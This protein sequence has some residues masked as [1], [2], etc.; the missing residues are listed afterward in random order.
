MQKRSLRNFF[1]GSPSP[2]TGPD[3]FYLRHLSTPPDP[4]QQKAP[5]LHRQVKG[6]CLPQML[7]VGQGSVCGLGALSCMWCCVMVL[8]VVRG[9]QGC[10]SKAHQCACEHVWGLH[11]LTCMYA[12]VRYC[13]HPCCEVV[14]GWVVVVVEQEDWLHPWVAR[15][16]AAPGG[17][18]EVQLGGG[19]PGGAQVEGRRSADGY[20]SGWADWC[21]WWGTQSRAC[22]HVAAPPC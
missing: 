13:G 12:R 6:W 18:T 2:L 21:R 5:L 15:L 17:S 4:H 14:G 16:R 11:G 9:L 1:F 19:C 3:W 8:A 10:W 7:G 22:R 20:R